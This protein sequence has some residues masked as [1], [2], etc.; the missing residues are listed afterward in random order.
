MYPICPVGS[1]GTWFVEFCIIVAQVSVLSSVKISIKLN[2]V[3][4]LVEK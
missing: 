1:V 2:V 3:R 4:N